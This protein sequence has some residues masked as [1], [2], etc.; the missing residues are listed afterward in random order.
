MPPPSSAC[1]PSLYL[2]R[3]LS[4]RV[5]GSVIRIVPC[6]K[7]TNG[8]LKIVKTWKFSSLGLG[9][10]TRIIPEV[11]VRRNSNN[12]SNSFLPLHIFSNFT[13]NFVLF[14]ICFPFTKPRKEVATPARRHRAHG[15]RARRLDDS[16][17]LQ[18]GCHEDIP[19]GPRPWFCA[20][21]CHQN[22]T[23][24]HRIHETGVFPYTF[25]VDF[26]MGKC[27]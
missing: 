11:G 8:M 9:V 3:W 14:L 12:S 15:S 18:K 1:P 10:H 20:S 5:D 24:S 16:P 7:T 23:L 25:I 21:S 4:G 13:R 22:Q 6:Q 27:R 26:L 17:I 2:E 19:M